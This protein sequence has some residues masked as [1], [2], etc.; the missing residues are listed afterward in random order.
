MVRLTNLVCAATM[1]ALLSAIAVLTGRMPAVHVAACAAALVA[2]RSGKLGNGRGVL[3]VGGA[4][5][6]DGI[7]SP[8]CLLGL[9]VF[10][11]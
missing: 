6:G 8:D 4:T 10:V 9:Y 2:M 5:G 3:Q 1:P 7:V 11:S